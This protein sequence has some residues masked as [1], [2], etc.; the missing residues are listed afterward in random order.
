MSR[1][2]SMSKLIEA[3]VGEPRTVGDIMTAN[4][5]T[6]NEE[7]DL[8]VLQEEMQNFGLR[9]IPVVDGKKLVG[10]VTHSDLLAHTLGKLRESRLLDALDRQEKR[11]TFVADIM[12]RDV[13]TA[14]LDTPIGQAAAW[15]VTGRFGCLP[16]IDDEGTL[17]GIVSE[18]DLAKLLAS[19]WS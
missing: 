1:A 4:P 2:T 8:A 10:L 18:S 5:I 19:H 11:A 6:L 14:R 7:D 17:L 15:M 3:A 9:H 13:Q 12:T 16:V